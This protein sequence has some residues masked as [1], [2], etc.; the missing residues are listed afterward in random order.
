MSKRILIV[1]GGVIGLCTAYYASREGHR[2]TL[3]E[4]GAPDHD[5][6][7][8][9]NAGL[10]VPSHFVPLAAPGMV[11]RGITW[12]WNPESPFYV[13]PR[14]S[15]DLWSW[16]WKFW[17]AA[18]A[19]RVERAAPLL[20][21]LNLASRRCFEELAGA[22][23]HE[24]GLVEKGLLLLCKTGRAFHEEAATAARARRLGLSAEVLTPEQAAHLEPGLRMDIAGAVHFPQ[25]CHLDP[26]RFVRGL[27]RRLE[28]EGVEFRWGTEVTGWRRASGSIESVATTGGPLQA[29]DYVVAGGAWSPPLVRDLGLTLP[30]QAGKGYSLTLPN[31]KRLPGVPFI[32]TE[33]RV[34]VTP[35]GGRL[36]FGGTMEI[37][38]LD[39]SVNPA[40][41][42]GII[43]SVPRYLPDFRPADFEGL[44]VWRGLRPCSPDGLPYL[45][46]FR[47]FTNLWVATGH[48]M[49]GLSLGPITGQLL[50]GMLSGEEP[51]FDLGLLDPGRYE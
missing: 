25:D 13:R 19:A 42:R 4:R 7:S 5:S 8:L 46:R 49:M 9:G 16:G 29:D 20:R 6:C 2:V 39:E 24:F 51:P 14:L 34:A 22:S 15:R 36:R 30:M 12:M 45:G 48:A 47:R 27:T 31:P 50:A 10:V 43:K 44:P 17:R 28:Q 1:G 21:D 11:A 18:R 41:V 35:M 38:G 3:V 32:L 40:R 23:G 33:A 26:E 37:A